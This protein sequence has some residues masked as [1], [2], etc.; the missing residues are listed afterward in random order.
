[1][2]TVQS[3]YAFL[4][5]RAPFDIQMSFDNAGLLVGRENQAVTKVLVTLD[6]TLPVIQEAAAWGAELI[7]SHHPVIFFPAKRLTDSRTDIVGQKLRALV[8]RDIS[9]ICCHTNLDAIA[10]GVNDALAQAVGLSDIRQLKQDGTDWHGRPYGIGR[11][12]ELPQKTP[13]ADYLKH[14][15]SA[16]GSNGLRYCDGGKACHRVAVGGGACSDMMDNAIAAGCDTF[17]TADVKYDGFLDARSMGLNL[18]DAG[19]Y[20]TEQVVVPV[21]AGW[22]AEEFPDVAVRQTAVHA[23]VIQYC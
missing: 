18:I 4:N 7:V 22:L 21:L 12:G 11:V 10:G 2:T 19:H 6:I 23:E 15:K 16:L 1:M 8:Q 9:A 5:R 3:V 13:L 20:P 17:I 14:V